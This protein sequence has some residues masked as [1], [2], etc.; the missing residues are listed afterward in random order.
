MEKLKNKQHH[1]SQAGFTLL[2]T[3]FVLFM[4]S[5]IFSL[6]TFSFQAFQSQ[7]KQRQFIHQLTIDLYEAQT[8]AI[9]Y[10]T[11]V[12]VQFYSH[13]YHVKTQGGKLLFVRQLPENSSVQSNSFNSFTF[14]PNGNTN[15]FGT[16]KFQ[17]ENQTI[18]CTFFIGKGRFYVEKQ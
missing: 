4:V 2:E 8:Y 12:Y 15:R 11:A 9:H 14:Y 3:L 13:K 1:N 5:I 10:E 18:K 6:A 17:I 7:S 16:I